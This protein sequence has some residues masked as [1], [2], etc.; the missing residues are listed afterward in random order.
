MAR[1]ALRQHSRQHSGRSTLCLRAWSA[2]NHLNLNTAISR[3]SFPRRVIRR[4]PSGAAIEDTNIFG[5]YTLD[6]EELFD[7]YRTPHGEFRGRSS[8][9]E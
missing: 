9:C 7:S 8:Q 1:P 4:E 6:D 2:L 5:C 3:L